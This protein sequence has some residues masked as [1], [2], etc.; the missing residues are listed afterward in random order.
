MAVD[1]LMNDGMIL[2]PYKSAGF[3]LVRV[4]R[5]TPLAGVRPRSIRKSRLPHACPVLAIAI[6]VGLK[7]L[8][9]GLYDIVS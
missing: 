6:I 7:V 5:M 9:F 4:F 1:V 8:P 2:Y 3:A